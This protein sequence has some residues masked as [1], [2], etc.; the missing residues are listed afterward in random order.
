MI[1]VTSGADSASGLAKPGGYL[2]RHKIRIALWIAV[3]EGV[4]VVVGVLPSILIYVLAVIAVG[5]YAFMGR[6][7]RSATARAGAWIFGVSQVLTAFVPMIWHVTKFAAE[8]AIVVIAVAGLI[9]LF[10][11]RDRHRS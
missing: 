9:L 11:E 10:T 3:V 1:F 4:L 5:F 2:A 8:I 7:Y 6:N